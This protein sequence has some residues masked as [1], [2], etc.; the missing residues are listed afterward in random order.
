MKTEQKD[1]GAELQSFLVSFHDSSVQILTIKQYML[2]WYK[3]V[4]KLEDNDKTFL[5][6]IR[7]R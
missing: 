4:Y 7:L 3:V 2:I 1:V 5:K 6:I